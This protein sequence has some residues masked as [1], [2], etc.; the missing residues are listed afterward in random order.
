MRLRPVT[1]LRG[2][3]E[4]RAFCSHE[5]AAARPLGGVMSLSARPPVPAAAAAA[6]GPGGL[7]YGVGLGGCEVAGDVVLAV[8]APSPSCMC[9]WAAGTF[10]GVHGISPSVCAL[11]HAGPRWPLKYALTVFH[12]LSAVLL[13]APWE[14]EAARLFPELHP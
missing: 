4:E 13:H 6:A 2:G 1:L 9:A 8:L 12:V 5:T 10:M 7:R 14:S 3:V 11:A